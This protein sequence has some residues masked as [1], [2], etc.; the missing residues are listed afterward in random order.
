MR[1][2]ITGERGRLGKEV[3]KVFKEDLSFVDKQMDIRNS[4]RVSEV[5][6]EYKPDIIIHL[7]A[8]T[9]VTQCEENKKLAWDT[10]VIGTMNLIN[11]CERYVPNTYFILMSTPCVFDGNDKKAKDE[12]SFYKPDNYYGFTK[13]VSE[14]F[15]LN[16]KLKKRLI[17]RAN[18][19]PYE[20]Y[21]H[22][23]AFKDRYSNYLFAHQIAN[24][25]KRLIKK[26]TEGI[27]HIC[28]DKVMSM[29]QLAR[30]C[31]DS[32][33]IK[34]IRLNNQNLTKYMILSSKR[35]KPIKISKP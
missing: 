31:P 3:C 5:V 4:D 20:K 16:S 21:P 10:N 15:L 8:L 29:F 33:N 28:G 7:A 26:K 23:K 25:I 18:F 19:V 11:A 1:I 9:S 24:K 6:K 35:L 30:L 27:V 22:K 17:I 12:D 34:P 32:G 2:C 14:Q 13:A